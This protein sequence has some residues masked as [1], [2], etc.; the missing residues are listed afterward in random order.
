MPSTVRF[1]QR[2]PVRLFSRSEVEEAAFMAAKGYCKKKDA[3]LLDST[4]APLET[5]AIQ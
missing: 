3:A 4:Q 5:L 1:N 2:M